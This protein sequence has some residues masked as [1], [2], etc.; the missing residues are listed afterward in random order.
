MMLKS[1]D[2]QSLFDDVILWVSRFEDRVGNF[3]QFKHLQF[4]TNA[5]I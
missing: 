1:I 2:I 5:L 4:G 3:M